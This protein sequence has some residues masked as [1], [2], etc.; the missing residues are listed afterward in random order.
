MIFWDIT[1][2]G[3]F[4]ND[5]VPKNIWLVVEPTPLL[6]VYSLWKP[7]L[8]L[9]YSLLLLVC[10]L[11]KPLLTTILTITINQSCSKQPPS[12]KKT[13]KGRTSPPFAA[14]FLEVW[15][16]KKS[17]APSPLDLHHSWR[18]SPPKRLKGTVPSRQNL[19]ILS[20]EFGNSKR[21]LIWYMFASPIVKKH[22]IEVRSRQNLRIL[23]TQMG[24][25][26]EICFLICVSITS[27]VKKTHDESQKTCVK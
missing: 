10:S 9:I 24:I 3:Y 15:P 11:W 20:T 23:S 26:P 7:L 14:L 16:S 22:M 5:E 8:W 6:L 4:Q 13:N 12:S 2:K 19:R 17:P 18:H 25:H 1:M 21:F 27:I